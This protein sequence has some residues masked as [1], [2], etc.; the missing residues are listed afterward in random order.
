M[1]GLGRF[2]LMAFRRPWKVRTLATTRIETQF[3]VMP[4]ECDLNIHLT[5]SAYPKWLDLA[6][7]QYFAQI[8]AAGL[9]IQQGWR[10]VL[11]S[12][13]ITFI[14][15]IPPF[16]KITVTSE[17]LHWDKKYAYIEHQFLC[18][19]RVHAKALARVAVLKAGT[20]LPFG[21]MLNEID[22]QKPLLDKNIHP[23]DAPEIVKAKIALLKAK[24][25]HG[26]AGREEQ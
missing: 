14:R 20:V 12:Q 9:F 25:E 18:N 19:E 22:F 24:R 5:N 15:E 23:N 7:T 16:K 10:S 26:S 6:R 11:A 3:R 1:T 13:S 2:L 21:S 17:L 8:G 4:W